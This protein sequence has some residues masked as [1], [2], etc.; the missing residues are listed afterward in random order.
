MVGAGSQQTLALTNNTTAF[1]FAACTRTY[2]RRP[3]VSVKRIIKNGNEQQKAALEKR[4]TA[5]KPTHK[6]E[7][8]KQSAGESISET[9]WPSLSK[10]GG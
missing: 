3:E 1:R 8:E 5:Q 9:R 6:T 4:K 7:P 10:S 2:A